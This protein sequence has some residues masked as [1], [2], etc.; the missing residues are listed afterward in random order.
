MIKTCNGCRAYSWNFKVYHAYCLLDYPLVEHDIPNGLFANHS[1]KVNC[2]K[3]K[4]WKE[5]DKLSIFEPCKIK[6]S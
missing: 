6:I 5:F 4:T 1:P 2:P 3:P